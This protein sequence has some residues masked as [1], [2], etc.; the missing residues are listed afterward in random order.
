L[1]GA[2]WTASQPT[3]I[4]AQSESFAL[5]GGA[6]IMLRGRRGCGPAVPGSRCAVVARHWRE[7]PGAGQGMTR[8]PRS[9]SRGSRLRGARVW[10]VP[11]RLPGSSVTVSPSPPGR[12]VP[13]TKVPAAQDVRLG[14][15]GTAGEA[16]G[17][18]GGH[19]QRGPA[20]MGAAGG[21]QAAAHAAQP[22]HL[23]QESPRSARWSKERSGGG[24][25]LSAGTVPCRVLGGH[26]AAKVPEA[27]TK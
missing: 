13:W 19:R 27:M 21:R 20:V 6:S 2:A 8:G 14:G 7:G 1:L 4:D 5:I 15:S 11:P 10:P 17:V 16:A 12:Y 23:A 25:P 9:A 3:E 24:K 18:P 26:R 22:D